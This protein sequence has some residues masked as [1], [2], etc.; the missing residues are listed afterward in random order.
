MKRNLSKLMALTLISLPLVA[1]TSTAFAASGAVT[2]QQKVKKGFVTGKVVN[3]A[4]QPIVHAT[5]YAD[6]TLYYNTNVIGYTNEKGEYSLDIRQPAGTWNITAKMMLKYNGESIE[7]DLIPQNEDVVAGAAG[8]VRN[9]V[10][11]PSETTYGNLG[12]V[13]VRTALG[14]FPDI[15]KVKVTLKPVGKLADG[16]AGKTFTSG[17]TNTAD[18]YI[19]KN[20]MYGTYDVTVTLDGK[21]LFVKKAASGGPDTPFQKSFRGGFWKDFYSIR[22]VMWLEIS[23]DDCPDILQSCQGK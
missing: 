13:N 5:I 20:V 9:F 12:V 4:G 23:D 15:N 18:G 1:H 3:A 11:K 7:I 19:I 6:N 16:T 21:P 14:F 2:A 22:P 8:G 17:L 10:Y